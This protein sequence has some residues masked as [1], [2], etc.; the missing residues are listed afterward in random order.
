MVRRLALA[1]AA[2]SLIAAAPPPPRDPANPTCP[3]RPNRTD[4]REM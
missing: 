3:E 1:L 4:F 2:A